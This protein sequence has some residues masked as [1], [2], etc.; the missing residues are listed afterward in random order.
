MSTP[1]SRKG[2]NRLFEELE[3]LKKERPLIAK[4]IQEAREEG[5]LSEN[6]GYDAARER[7]GMQEARISYLESRLPLLDVVDFSRLGGGKVTYGARVRLLD[8]DSEEEKEYVIL[9]PD[10]FDLV[11]G[12]ISVESPVA[13]ALLGREEGE[14]VIVSVPRGKVCYEILDI[15]FPGAAM[16]EAL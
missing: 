7:Q 11:K 4:I 15:S 8:Q 3:Q 14:E 6:A 10:E 9:G 12:G 1:V 2:F 5:D 13:R 16:F